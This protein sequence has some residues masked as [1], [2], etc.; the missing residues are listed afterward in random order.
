MEDVSLRFV[1][2]R[3]AALPLLTPLSLCRESRP[4]D[5][6]ADKLDGMMDIVFA[7]LG[8]YVH[9]ACASDDSSDDQRSVRRRISGGDFDGTVQTLLRAFQLSLLQTYKSKF[10]QASLPAAHSVH[11]LTP[12]RAVS[13]ILRMH[14]GREHACC[15]RLLRFAGASA[16]VELGV[17]TH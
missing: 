5:E 12:A 10:T 15:L 3:C 9:A 8:R 2:Q 16:R 17:L 13:R 6:T 14:T 4:I 1:A 11:T 7:H